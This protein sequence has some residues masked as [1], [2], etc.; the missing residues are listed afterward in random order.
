MFK[1]MGMKIIVIE[2]LDMAPSSFRKIA[3]C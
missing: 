1:F 3:A 2:N